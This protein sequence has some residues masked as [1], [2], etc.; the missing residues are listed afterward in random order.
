M[1]IH[2][3]AA[4]LKDLQAMVELE[5]QCFTSEAFSR[6]QLS[7]LLKA[8]NSINLTAK[9]NGELA[10]FVILQLENQENIVFGHIV[11]LNV[12]M[13]FRRIGVAQKLLSECEAMLKLHGVTECRL[14]V[15]KTNS[16][17]LNLYKQLGYIEVG[18]LEKYY[19]NEHGLYLKK[20]FN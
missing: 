18:V 5:Q 16:A 11:T 15:R 13:L 19:D 20:T 4:S 12:A 7:Y 10:G 9:V 1:D 6:Q 3:D 8:Y 17:A 2:I 14:E